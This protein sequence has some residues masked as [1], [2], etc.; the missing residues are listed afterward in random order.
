M[1]AISAY[2]LPL[3]SG[4]KA[5]MKMAPNAV[6]IENRNM[7][8]YRP[9]SSMTD[10][11]NFTITNART[12]DK[13][14]QIVHPTLRTYLRTDEMVVY[15]FLNKNRRRREREKSYLFG[16]HFGNHNKHER[17][18]PNSSEEHHAGET[19][20][21]NPRV[22]LHIESDR[23]CVRISTETRK[24]NRRSDCRRNQENF[25]TKAIHEKRRKVRANQLD[26]SN[27]YCRQFGRNGRTALKENLRCVTSLKERMRTTS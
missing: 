7:Q 4:M 10:S 6:Q 9:I 16:H 22:W 2:V 24:A 17:Y 26:Q 23:M 20:N 11:K 8:P 19:G 21:R 14:K 3:V 25:T 12:Q 27:D 15:Y 1:A 18:Q 5:I 13:Q